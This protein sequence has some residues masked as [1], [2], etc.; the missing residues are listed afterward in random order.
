MRILGGGDDYEIV[1]T[2]PPR[3]VK[4]FAAQARKAGVGVSAIGRIVK[5]TVPPRFLDARGESVDLQSASFS[6][7]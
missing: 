3:R 4:A 2:V 1:C 7:F 5:G 6:H